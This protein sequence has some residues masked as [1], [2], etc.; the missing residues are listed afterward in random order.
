[1]RPYVCEICKRAEWRGKK[2]PLEVDH[3]DG[4]FK[5]NEFS[6]LRL[7]CRNCHGQTPTFGAKNMGNGRKSRTLVSKKG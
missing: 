5:N 3:I 1:M 6:N 4:N 7:L 2:I